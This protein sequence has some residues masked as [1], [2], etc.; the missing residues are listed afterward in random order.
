VDFF[1]FLFFVLVCESSTMRMIGRGIIKR[2][3][4]QRIGSSKRN[5]R[6][7]LFHKFYDKE[8]TFEEN[9]KRKPVGIEANHWKKFLEYW[10]NEDT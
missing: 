3:I 5:A 1:G 8:L 2:E 10:L 9:L 4:V 7:Y 6:N